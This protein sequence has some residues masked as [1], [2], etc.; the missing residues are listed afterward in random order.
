[1]SRDNA[2]LQAAHEG[3][4]NV[5]RAR[6]VGRW[7]DDYKR[8]LVAVDVRPEKAALVPPVEMAGNRQACTG[9]GFEDRSG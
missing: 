6:D 8:R 7:Q 1:M 2:H 5:Q 4:A 3:M 9:S